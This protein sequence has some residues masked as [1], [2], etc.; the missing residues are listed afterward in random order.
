M[1]RLN[2]RRATEEEA[3]LFITEARQFAA[4]H[5]QAAVRM[6]IFSLCKGLE[7]ARRP[8]VPVIEMSGRLVCAEELIALLNETSREGRSVLCTSR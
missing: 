5:P 2:W 1:Q 6:F 3:K 8:T 7:L 4:K